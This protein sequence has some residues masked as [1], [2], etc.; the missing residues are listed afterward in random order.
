M[1]LQLTRRAIFGNIAYL[2]SGTAI[3]QAITAITTLLI[4]RQLGPNS[5]GQVAASMVFVAFTSVIFSLGLN[6]WL[7]HEASRNPQEQKILLGSVLAIKTIIGIPWLIITYLLAGFVNSSTFPKEI[8]F[9]SALVI[10][11]DNIFST[12]LTS[13]KVIFK[14]QLTF[15]L[16]LCSDLLWMLGTIGLIYINQKSALIYIGF[17]ASTLLVSL[18]VAGWFAWRLIHPE[19]LTTNM[20]R[21]LKA[22]FPYATSEF[23][24]MS[25]LRID[26]LIVAFYLGDQAAGLYSPAVGIINAFFLP[27]SAISGVILPILSNQFNHNSMLAWKTAKRATW[28]FVILGAAI[29]I[30]IGFLAQFTTVL[31]GSSYSA[32]QEI[33]LILSIILFFHAIIVAMT[34]I[35]IATDQQAKR[36]II[37]TAAVIFNIVLDVVVVQWAG[38]RG[39]AWG[40][41]ITEVFMLIGLTFLVISFK[42]RSDKL[43]IHVNV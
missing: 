21:A 37:Q 29:A 13:F 6:T 33:V 35:L 23:L 38:I 19:M 4:A 39:A 28:L 15:I 24:T 8:I 36:A 43:A 31:L 20:K 9:L 41:V 1:Q 27:L 30:M 5:Y 25:S 12:F 3:T 22:S 2:F 40:Y 14:N 42:S 16:M 7:L 26:V 18:L 17:R 11:F 10:L 32:S 34:N